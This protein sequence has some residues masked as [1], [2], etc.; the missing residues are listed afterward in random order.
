[1]DV[2]GCWKVSLRSMTP[3]ISSACGHVPLS[4]SAPIHQRIAAIIATNNTKNC[5]SSVYVIP[6]IHFGVK[7]VL[8]NAV[9]LG[10]YRGAGRPEAIYL[11]E[12]LI[13][14]AAQ[15]MNIDPAELRL[16]NFIPPSAMP[17]TTP[18]GPI[19]DSGEFEQF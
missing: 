2:T 5:L 6:A 3:E 12:R 8:T 9:P 4:A 11:I 7:M 16:R 1:M 19:Y 10:P 14:K 13:D 15:A 18:N 17:Y